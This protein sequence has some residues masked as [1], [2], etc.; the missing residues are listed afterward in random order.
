LRFTPNDGLKG[1]PRTDRIVYRPEEFTPLFVAAA[2][3]DRQSI[4][5][6]LKF[7]IS[8]ST[9]RHRPATAAAGNRQR[10]NAMLGF[11][12]STPTGIEQNLNKLFKV[13]GKVECRLERYVNGVDVVSAP[14]FITTGEFTVKLLESAIR[15]DQRVIVKMLVELGASLEP[16]KSEIKQ[17]TPLHVAACCGNYQICEYLLLNGAFP[18]EEDT[19]GFTAMDLALMIGHPQ[20]TRLF[21]RISPPPSTLVKRGVSL[22]AFIFSMHDAGSGILESC[23]PTRDEEAHNDPQLPKRALPVLDIRTPDSCSIPCGHPSAFAAQNHFGFSNMADVLK[24]L[25]EHGCDLETIERNWIPKD[26]CDDRHRLGGSHETVL[27]KACLMANSSL[28]SF[29]VEN[30]AKVNQKNH[31][32]ETPLHR[33]CSRHETSEEM[34]RI[35]VQHGADPTALDDSGLSVFY[36]ACAGVAIGVV[37]CL[38][39]NGAVVKVSD[40]NKYHPLHATCARR[41]YEPAISAD[42]I[43][44]IDYIV[45]C[46]GRD[47]LSVE[48][49][50]P[51][52]SGRANIPLHVAIESKNW[53]VVD[54][55]RALGVTATDPRCLSQ[56]LWD[57]AADACERPFRCLVDLGAP[58]AGRCSSYQD[59]TIIAHYLDDY[60]R[61]GTSPL[62][63]RFERNLGALLR[64]GAD[65][66]ACSYFS[67]SRT[68][69]KITALRM[70]RDAG[71][72]DSFVQ[73]LLR[74]GAVEGDELEGE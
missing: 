31:R 19:D 69:K 48:C 44:I 27:H 36:V 2:A 70:A 40:D 9:S 3:G 7:G 60:L 55:L 39:A 20:C 43:K 8:T 52:Y 74:H 14:S 50:P 58:V 47:V 12:L 24:A 11:E 41:T 45:S 35:L 49:Q 56:D 6:M 28:V 37:Q 38:V 29:L 10:I 15:S 30:G 23:M 4:E 62:N 73:I 61:F 51:L 26:R 1:P 65:I 22:T 21:L 66:N 64:A 67:T 34:I 32:G 13:L 53:E 5:A 25:L 57:Y 71:L 18:Y 54:H 59:K 72:D 16:M 68:T 46:S 63:G 17:R 33:A 42:S